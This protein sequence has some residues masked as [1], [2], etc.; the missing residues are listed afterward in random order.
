MV[1]LCVKC[2]CDF[3]VHELKCPM[4]THTRMAC[5]SDSDLAMRETSRE[6]W[7]GEALKWQLHTLCTHTYLPPHLAFLRLLFD[8]CKALILPTEP[9]NNLYCVHLLLP[10]QC[11]LECV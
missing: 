4:H 7:H 9:L 5:V 6:Y 10:A 1:C 2:S 11:A 3:D 8:H